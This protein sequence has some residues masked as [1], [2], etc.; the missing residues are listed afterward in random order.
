VK[1]VQEMAEARDTDGV[2]VGSESWDVQKFIELAQICA[3]F[4]SNRK[5]L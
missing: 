5:A 1:N 4:V 3:Q 2:G